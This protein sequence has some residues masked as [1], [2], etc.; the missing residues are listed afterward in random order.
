MGLKLADA[1]VFLGTEDSGLKKGFDSAKEQTKS[2]AGGMGTIV[3][4]ALIGMGQAITGGIIDLAHKAMDGIG[5]SISK[6]SDLNETVSKIDTLFGN[7]SNQILDWS[8]D[9]AKAMGLSKQAALDAVGSIGNMFVQLGA[10]TDKAAD[11][12]ESMTQLS[13]DIAS[14]HNVAGGTPAVLEAVQAGFR[15]EYD[16]LQRYIPTISAATVE[17][18]A[19]SETHKSSAKDLTALEKAYAVQT[20]VM[21]DAGAAT[22]DFARTSNGLANQQRITE[23]QMTNLSTAIGQGVIPVVTA[24]QT[25]FNTL[26]S[27]V[28]PDI[29]SFIQDNVTPAMTS[30]ADVIGGFVERIQKAIPLLGDLN[31]GFEDGSGPL[32]DFLQIFGVGKDLAQKIGQAFYDLRETIKYL[33]ENFSDLGTIWED[34]SS[35]LETFLEKLGFAKPIATVVA[36][37]LLVVGNAI[38]AVVSGIVDWVSGN[39]SLPDVLGQIWAKISKTAEYALYSVVSVVKDNLPVWE[40]RLLEWG[41]AAG[42]WIVDATPVVLGKLGDLLG[43]IIGDLIDWI[44]GT[45][46]VFWDFWNGLV[47]VF[48][49]G[50][51]LLQGNWEMAW[52]DLQYAAGVGWRAVIELV[53]QFLPGWITAIQGWA[54]ASW[55]WITDTAIPKAREKL[56]EWGSALWSWAKE[57]APIWATKLGDFASKTWDWLI[58]DVIPVVGDKL[59]QWG[60]ALWQWVTDNAPTWGSKFAEWA[61]NAWKWIVDVRPTVITKLGELAGDIWQWAKDNAPK[62]ADK[63]AEWAAIAW[64]WIIDAA[65]A[66]PGKLGEW[67]T[68]LTGWFNDNKQK[69]IDKLKEWGDKLWGWI[70]DAH[71]GTATKLSEWW[72][73]I[74]GK[75]IEYQPLLTREVNGWK[76]IILELFGDDTQAQTGTKADNWFG[77]LVGKMNGTKDFLDTMKTKFATTIVEWLTDA[78]P[79]TIKA[80]TDWLLTLGK[81]VDPSQNNEGRLALARAQLALDN[82]FNDMLKAIELAL[83]DSASRI[84]LAIINGIKKGIDDN[85]GGLLTKMTDLANSALSAAKA[86]LGIQS[87]STEFRNVGI[88]SIQ[89]LLDGMDSMY[90]NVKTKAADLAQLAIKAARDAVQS[91]AS[92]GWTEAEKAATAA[93]YSTAAGVKQAAQDIL[94]GAAKDAALTLTPGVFRT[95]TPPSPQTKTALQ[96]RPDYDKSLNNIRSILLNRDFIGN[97]FGMYEDDPRI[98][99]LFSL[100]DNIQ[101]MLNRPDTGSSI[102]AIMEALQTGDFRG[103][104]FGLNEDNPL[105]SDIF[106]FQ[107]QLEKQLGIHSPSSY[108]DWIGDMS[109]QGFVNG[110]RRNM[111]DVTGIFEKTMNRIISSTSN[112]QT[113]NNLILQGSGYAPS[114]ALSAVQ[115]LNMHYR[116][117]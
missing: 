109:S 59:G 67:W 84:G 30:V 64:Q 9:S 48:D 45:N 65:K 101:S 37:A 24:L 69:W 4:G 77:K 104:I 71:P 68:D 26:L 98:S 28:M 96:Q 61:T 21:R 8:N 99:L 41:S 112:I 13:A 17:Q 36:A 11:V 106:D 40:A 7:S 72:E 91:V 85:T 12:G 88:M 103:G 22:G 56:N 51:A 15:G 42:Q 115:L 108:F 73:V 66:V 57:N 93:F 82:A 95:G 78:I 62:W 6:A 81:G 47:D 44:P 29:T 102:N 116:N 107:D 54:N 76:V 18:E 89:G 83:W 100:H 86:A 92:T 2:W 35:I 55:Q 46:R 114:D 10:G 39:A 38:K 60:T 5:D 25:G 58:H 19:L 117:A 34:G 53:N 49:A 23:A 80:A 90:A 31:H 14:F 74:K 27:G 79:A 33:I 70:E 16:A 20:I 97:I 111:D 94:M 3:Q 52:I 32:M 75:L 110:F 1:L 43:N 50:K 105:L 63:L 87:P 113:T